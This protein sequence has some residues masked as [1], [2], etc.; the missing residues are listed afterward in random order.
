[1][2]LM[3]MGF[4]RWKQAPTSRAWCRICESSSAHV[5]A[6]KNIEKYLCSFYFEEK[7]GMNHPVSTSVSTSKRKKNKEDTEF[8]YHII[9]TYIS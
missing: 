6:S 7:G 9:C 2:L 1:M 4:T 8:H 3:V 5:A